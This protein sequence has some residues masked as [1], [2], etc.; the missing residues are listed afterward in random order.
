[1]KPRREDPLEPIYITVP[2]SW[3]AVMNQ[4]CN[5][6]DTTTNAIVRNA[7]AE[8]LEKHHQLLVY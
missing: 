1:M 8:Y 7:I 6:S 5:D 2:Y 4:V 3:I